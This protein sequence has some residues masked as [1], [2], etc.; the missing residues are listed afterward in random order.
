MDMPRIMSAE[1]MPVI[2]TWVDASYAVHADMK[3]CLGGAVSLGRGL[4]MSSSNKQKLN[5][6]SSTKADLVGASSYL[7]TA[8][9]SKMFIESQ[10]Y[11]VE[12]NKFY[13]DNQSTTMKFEKNGRNSCG[14]QSRHIYI[15]YFWIKDRLDKERIEVIHCPT[16]IM[17]ADFFTKPLQGALFKKLRDIIMGITHSNSLQA[18]TK[19]NIASSPGACWK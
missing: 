19:K 5:T 8:V 10:G 6:K 3:S 7:P 16:D 2:K 9:W 1:S 11:K 17:V 18:V 14:K 15:R 13:Q 4:I 12:V